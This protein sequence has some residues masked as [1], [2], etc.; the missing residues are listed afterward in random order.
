MPPLNYCI[1]CN[2]LDLERKLPPFHIKTNGITDIN[3]L[4][5]P[6][7]LHAPEIPK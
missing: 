5:P 4:R 6:S 3:A 7:K 2:N 1:D